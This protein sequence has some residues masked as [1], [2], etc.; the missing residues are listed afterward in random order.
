VTQNPRPGKTPAEATGT[1]TLPK[2]LFRGR[3]MRLSARQNLLIL[4]MNLGPSLPFR[5]V[6]PALDLPLQRQT[7]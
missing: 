1:P 2:M 3:L 7:Q 5:A 6:L 4:H